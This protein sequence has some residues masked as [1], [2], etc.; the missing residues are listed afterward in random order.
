MNNKSRYGYW[1]VYWIIT[2]IGGIASLLF[3]EVLTNVFAIR[4]GLLSNHLSYVQ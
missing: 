3:C 1:T 4:L 2:N